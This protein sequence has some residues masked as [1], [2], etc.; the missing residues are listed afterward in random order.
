MVP[1]GRRDMI[2][3]TDLAMKILSAL[4]LPLIGWG[5]HLSTQVAVLESKVSDYDDQVTKVVAVQDRVTKA[6][7]QITQLHDDV[8]KALGQQAL[9]GQTSTSIAVL[10]TRLNAIVKNLDEIKDLLKHPVPGGGDR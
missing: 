6:E 5:F 4:T 10:E 3:Y 1:N 2:K 7:T 8:I 9:I